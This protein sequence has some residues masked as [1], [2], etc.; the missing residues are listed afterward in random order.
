LKDIALDFRFH[1]DDQRGVFVV[2]MVDPSWEVGEDLAFDFRNQRLTRVLERIERDQ[3]TLDDLREIGVNLWAGLMTGKVGERFEALR[4]EI[5]PEAGGREQVRFQLRLTLPPELEALPWESLYH[6][7]DFG[8]IACHPDHCVLRSPPASIKPPTLP[9]PHGGKLKI[10]AV[11]PSGSGLN[12]EHEW[13]NLELAVSKLRDRVDLERLSGRVDADRLGEHLRTQ[14]SRGSSSETSSSTA[15]CA[16]PCS[17][18]A[19][20]PSPRLCA[21]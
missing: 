6:E 4:K 10:L 5:E 3:C 14:R 13:H 21:A 17:T 20:A 11:I 19:W 2:H 18:A 9:P 16:S 1:K 15:A 8:F 7:K 12:A